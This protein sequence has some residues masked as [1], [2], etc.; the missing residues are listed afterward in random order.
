MPPGMWH[1][2]YTPVGGMSSGGH[3]QLYDTMHLMYLACTFDD[4]PMPHVQKKMILCNQ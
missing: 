1:M 4:L 2:V 3:F